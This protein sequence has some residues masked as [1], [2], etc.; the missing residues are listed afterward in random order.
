[1][2]EEQNRRALDA[3]NGKSRPLRPSL[4][5]ALGALV[6]VLVT[7]SA[8]LVVSNR[9]TTRDNSRAIAT[10]K[11]AAHAKHPVE[12]EQFDALRDAFREHEIDGKRKHALIDRELQHE[13]EALDELKRFMNEGG[14][15]TSDQGAALEARIRQLETQII[16]C[17]CQP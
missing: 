8:G 15:F 10:H 6:V 12:W 9:D 16:K 7:T 4:Q 2:N 13:H 3:V 11:E 17:R 1:M 5:N 14:R